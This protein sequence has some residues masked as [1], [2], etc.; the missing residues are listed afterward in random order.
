M[1]GRNM[2]VILVPGKTKRK[3]EI[4]NRINNMP[5]MKSNKGASKTFKKTASGSSKEKSL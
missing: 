1:E 3:K 2:N 4:N 5:K